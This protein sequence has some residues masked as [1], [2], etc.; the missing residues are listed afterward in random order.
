MWRQLAKTRP[1]YYWELRSVFKMLA[2]S[3]YFYTVNMFAQ[4]NNMN[5]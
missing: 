4:N 1:T 2:G 5:H 3:M